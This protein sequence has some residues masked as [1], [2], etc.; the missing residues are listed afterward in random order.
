VRADS[1]L[2]VDVGVLPGEPDAAPAE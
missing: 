1:P 2:G